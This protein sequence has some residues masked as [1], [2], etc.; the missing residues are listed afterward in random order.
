MSWSHSNW[1]FEMRSNI[2]A[3]F[4]ATVV[5][6]MTDKSDPSFAISFELEAFNKVSSKTADLTLY[7]L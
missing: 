5:K 2:G 7:L 6:S 1:K 4:W 3:V